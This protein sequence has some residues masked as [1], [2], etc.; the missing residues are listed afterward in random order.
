MTSV[1]HINDAA[2]V[3]PAPKKRIDYIDYLKG[4]TILWVVWYHTAHPAFVDFSFRI[5]LFFFVSGIFFKPY[6]LKEFI[7][8]KVNTL[9]VPFVVFY[10]I[11]YVYYIGL[12]WLAEGS[13]SNFEWDT[14]LGVFELHRATQ[15]FPINPPLW[16]ICALIVLQ[17]LLYGLVK[18]GMSRTWMIISALAFSA[19][20]VLWLYDLYT[21]IMIS[22]SSRYFVYYAFGYIFGKQLLEIIE[23]HH[24]WRA[25]VRL[26]LT[27]LLVFVAC[28]Q[29]KSLATLPYDGVQLLEY[30]E[31]FALILFMVY[32][33]K[34]A[35]RLPLI[36]F[37]RFYGFNS[38]IVLGMHEIILT[39]L[40]ISY[41][42]IFA[43]DPDN[44][45]G[46]C[47]LVITTVVLWPVI[48]FFNRYFPKFVGK[49]PLWR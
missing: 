38:Y 14:I 18:S 13:L 40:L 48:L 19:I 5:P 36:R 2:S 12:Y 15:G 44:V 3:K 20:G 34:F 46:V 8:K 35:S 28:W 29:F 49:N 30:V 25:S 37:L 9:L 23:G 41:H 26:G 22:R 39:L 45:A 7:K 33:L 32:L 47:M 6:P 21:P 17:F 27:G 1:T 11:Y 43:A 4:L 42:H 31:T 16:F 10:L 24:G